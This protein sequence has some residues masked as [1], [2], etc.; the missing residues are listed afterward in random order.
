MPSAIDTKAGVGLEVGSPRVGILVITAN[1]ALEAF[2]IESADGHERVVI[3]LSGHLTYLFPNQSEF[4]FTLPRAE[5]I[6]D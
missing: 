4:C 5:W 1:R 2:G 6:V 3:C